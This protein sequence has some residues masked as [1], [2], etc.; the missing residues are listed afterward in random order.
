M[1]TSAP[2]DTAVDNHQHPVGGSGN[3]NSSKGPQYD[4]LRYLDKPKLT[5]VYNSPRP[6]TPLPSVTGDN[7][8]LDITV[9]D[10]AAAAPRVT[11]VITNIIIPRAM[12]LL[13]GL[14]FSTSL[15]QRIQVCV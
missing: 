15:R 5:D 11:H 10:V 2:K 7:T 12:A 13:R 6:S 8:A 9:L 14:S 4:A 1:P 3:G